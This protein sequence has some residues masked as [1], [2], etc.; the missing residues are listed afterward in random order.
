VAW[1]S[2]PGVGFAAVPTVGPYLAILAVASG[3]LEIQRADRWWWFAALL[4]G[5]PGSLTGYGWPAS[6]RSRRSS[7]CG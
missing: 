2:W 6:A 5:L 1:R 3:R 7:P 4:L